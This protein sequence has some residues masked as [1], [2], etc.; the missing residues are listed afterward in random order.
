MVLPQ[1]PSGGRIAFHSDRDGDSEV[2]VM[3]CDGTNQT[4]ITNNSSGDMQP[5]WGTGEKLAFSSNRNASGGYD[6]YLLTLAPWK[7]L[8][9]T[10]DTARDESPALSP[11]GT[12][13]AF[14]S[15]RDGNSEIYVA[16]LSEDMPSLTRIT[17]NTAS[18]ADPAWS[19]DGLRLLFAS[20]RDGDWD[21]YLTDTAWDN[22]SNLTDS[23][24]DDQDGD[25]E[26]WPDMAFYDYGDGTGENLVAF[27]SNR[28]GDWEIFTMG[29]DGSGQTQATANANGLEDAQPSWDPLAEYLTLHSNRDG[30]YKI[31]TMYYDGTDYTNVSRVGNSDSASS[32]DSSPDWE[33]VS[34]GAYCGG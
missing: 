13:V 1:F 33:P 2:Y 4:K 11:D 7:I 8:R 15:N 31:A 6:I 32:A 21:I 10:A 28:D 5:S 19:P 17:N 29:D 30:N 27:A 3:G 23:T 9:V 34:D 18:D 16:N 24:S 22:P 14:V 12:R 20:D 26:R 25:D